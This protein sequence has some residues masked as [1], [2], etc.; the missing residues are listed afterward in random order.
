MERLLTTSTRATNRIALPETTNI[1][2]TMLHAKSF[3]TQSMVT[4]QQTFHQ[5]TQ[6][7]RSKPSSLEAIFNGIH[8]SSGTHPSN[9]LMHG[10]HQHKHDQTHGSPQE[11]DNKLTPSTG[12]TVDSTASNGRGGQFVLFLEADQ[13][14]MDYTNKPP[15]EEILRLHR[16]GFGRAVWLKLKDFHYPHIYNCGNLR[17]MIKLEQVLLLDQNLI[18]GWSLE[19]CTAQDYARAHANDARRIYGMTDNID[20]D[21]L[22][23]LNRL[24]EPYGGPYSCAAGYIPPGPTNRSG[25]INSIPKSATK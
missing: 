1:P 2:S 22:N 14:G 18:E 21:Y 19:E 12:N 4:T 13:F 7:D 9:E 16:R 24:N 23:D 6:G 15:Y 10:E 17:H 11:I 8:I 3:T 20:R 5:K 25:S